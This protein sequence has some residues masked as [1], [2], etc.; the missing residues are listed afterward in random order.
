M[1]S[2]EK[3]P[4]GARAVAILAAVA[5][6]AALGY[7][8]YLT[9]REWAFSPFYLLPIC[10]AT[11]VAGRAGRATGLAVGALCTLAWFLGDM[12]SG[13]AYHHPLVPVW[14]AAM[15]FA[16]FV[17][18]VWLLAAFR[19]SHFDLEQ[20]VELRT[21]ALRAEIEE[22]KRLEQ[23]KL[24]GERLAVVGSMAAQVAH[25][26]R[27]PLGA[28]SLNL[29][30]VN[31]E[32][33]AALASGARFSSECQNLLGEMRS[34]VLRIHQVLQDYLRFGRMPKSD[35]AAVALNEL[36][37]EK[38]GFVRAFLDEN[39]IKVRE[40]IE[41][42][43]PSVHADPEQLWEAL[44]NLIRNAVD[45]MPNG[46]ILTIAAKRNGADA[47]VSVGDNGTGMT[48]A[49]ARNLFVPFFSTKTDG[50]GLGL[51]Y[52]QQVVNEHGGRI[53][54]ATVAGKGSV[55]TIHLPLA[56]ET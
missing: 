33:K 54:C 52:A 4:V 11:W 22:R 23:A 3:F 26:I 8:D 41:G 2:G 53:D 44:L 43:L 40:V 28:I 39:D 31:E 5:L 21:T 34:S 50:T 13:T 32:L 16:F 37:E 30:L 1:N 25:E 48:E 12:W 36:L 17:I 14:N 35:R 55:F 19:V 20:T 38:L 27:N 9:G 47:L 24:Q 6:T 56:R 7:L 46:G 42:D 15:L 49:Q 29:D 18:I 10:L 45:A 51:A